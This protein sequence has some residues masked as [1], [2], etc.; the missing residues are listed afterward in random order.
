M[1]RY[2]TLLLPLLCVGC[3]RPYDVPEYEEI[4][5]NETAF[6]LPL[7]GD[8]TQ[9]KAF[10]SEEFLEKNKVAGKR[11]QITHRWNA[12]GYSV[13]S[14][15]WIPT[16][17]LVKVS[18]AAV[19]R[20]WTKE[21]ATGTSAKDESVKVES[22]D[23]INF[24]AGFSVTAQVPEA[25][26]AKFLYRYGGATLPEVLDSEVRTRVTKVTQE[27][28]AEYDMDTL[29][30]KKG[31]ML[32]AVSRDV[33]DYYRERGIDITALAMVGGFAYDNPKIQESIDAAMQA[34]QLQAVAE[35]KLKAAE[36]DKKTA[37]L[38]AE[39]EGEAEAAR[40][41]KVVEANKY[42][43]EQLKDDYLKLRQLEVQE[44]F[45]EKW[46]GNVPTMMAGG[47]GF[48]LLMTLP[49]PEAKK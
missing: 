14:G 23:S 48:P 45:L 9:Q 1:T 4:A 49:A 46:T 18:R 29:R 20:S 25:S 38:R 27:F 21:A 30:A 12:T 26:T 34:Q 6:L 24:S 32:K 31:E 39:A 11:V 13:C 37:V 36:T 33:T 44:K 3:M 5:N 41:R 16:V 22:R 28:C 7:E 15:H 43:V 2:F 42:A 10:A 17:K 19:T 35:A 8:T 40:V 47:Q